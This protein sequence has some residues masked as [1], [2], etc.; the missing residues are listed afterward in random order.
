MENNDYAMQI[1]IH[2]QD[3][4]K[5]WKYDYI[6]RLQER[7][8]AQNFYRIFCKFTKTYFAVINGEHHNVTFFKDGSVTVKRCGKGFDERPFDARLTIEEILPYL[9]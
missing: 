5:E 4:C 3:Y 8:T 7:K 9:P 2:L 6:E 1:A